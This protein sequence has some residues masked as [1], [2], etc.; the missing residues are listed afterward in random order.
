MKA[1][2][3][4]VNSILR[5]EPINDNPFDEN[6]CGLF[7]EDI[8]SAGLGPAFYLQAK[9]CRVLPEP[10]RLKSRASYEDALLFKDY[11]ICCLKELQPALCRLGRVVII[12]GL[13][14][15][16]TIYREPSVRPMGDVDLYFPDGSIEE[17][18][19]VFL[20][21][22][23]T[24]LDAYRTVV[25]RG[26]LHVDLHEDLW[27]ARR[28]PRRNGCIPGL[29]ETFEES[30]LV[31]GFFIPSPSLLA[32]HSAYHAIKHCFSRKL[33]YL[34]IVLLHKAGYFKEPIT[35]PNSRMALIA[36]DHCSRIGLITETFS[37]PPLAF[38]RSA[39]LYALFSMK[40]SP[41]KGELALALTMPQLRDSL[42]YIADSLVPRKEI[43]IEMYGNKSFVSLL[44][45]RILVIFSYALGML[46]WKKT[47]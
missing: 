39:L 24:C 25:C 37:R 16:E 42:A 21:N 33:W 14:L 20:T 45:H 5:A 4:F 40:E 23:Y 10:V 18:R 11:A 1:S 46:L 19:N 13:A 31:P 26:D 47:R 9:E 35:N 8:K 41:G 17:A 3:R 15:C 12:K 6:G 38:Y 28:L 2:E 22:G 27:D 7:F 43:L 30:N 32:V 36:L 44:M 34:D 29:A